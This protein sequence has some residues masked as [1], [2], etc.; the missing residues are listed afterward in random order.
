[1]KHCMMAVRWFC[2]LQKRLLKDKSF[3]LILLL[4]PLFVLSLQFLSKEESGIVHIALAQEND[5]DALAKEICAD[6]MN[7]GGVL[8]FTEAETPGEA[9]ELV[10]NGTCD[11]AWIFPEDTAEEVQKFARRKFIDAAVVTVVQREENVITRL[12]REK[13]YGAL[14]S[15]CSYALYDAYLT[16]EVP[17]AQNLPEDEK[18]EIYENIFQAEDLFQY[19]YADGNEPKAETSYL[20]TPVRGFL[21]VLTVV[22]AL[23]ASMLYRKDLD[24]GAFVWLPERKQ[25]R[26]AV[27]YTVTAVLDVGILVVFALVLSGMS[28]SL[29]RECV[30]MLLFILCCSGFAMLIRLITGRNMVLGSCIPLFAVLM[31][32]TCPVFFHLKALNWLGALFPPYAYISAVY[33]D[34]HIL[35]MLIYAV[36]VYGLYFLLHKILKR[37]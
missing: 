25:S 8:R 35:S 16:K 6:L 27:L 37:I 34:R 2:L 36:A 9:V 30:L 4:I 18:R 17:E 20:L 15:H 24:N 29:I 14:Y 12:A 32:V 7:S 28:V 31:T 11:S 13:L 3:Q 10:K 22:G 5:N 23:A 33:N 19:I 26:Y 21:A 1:M